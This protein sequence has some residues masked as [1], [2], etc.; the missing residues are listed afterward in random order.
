M[1]NEDQ[2]V[3][4][5][6]NGEIY[7][8]QALRQRLEGAGHRLRSK[9]DTEVIVHL[10]EDEG[11]DSFRHLNGMFAIG[12][13]DAKRRRM[14]LARDRL[15]Q[16]PWSTMLLRNVCSSPVNSRVCYKFQAFHGRSIPQPSTSILP[17][18]TYPIP[19]LFSQISISCRRDILA[20][21]KMAGGKLPNIGHP[22]G[23][24]LISNLATIIPS[25]S[26]N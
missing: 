5:V 22:I 7:N 2:S 13:W 3:W 9:S 20:C 19:T 10:Y 24:G 6:F 14:V 21:F 4:V 11:L 1:A 8:Y 18:N 25:S 16:N 23:T 12:I 15:G 26:R 17:T